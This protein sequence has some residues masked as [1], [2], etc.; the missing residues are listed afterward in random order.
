MTVLSVEA[1]RILWVGF[2][3]LFSAIT[4]LRRLKNSFPS[5]KVILNREM[6]ISSLFYGMLIL[7]GQT[8]HLALSPQKPASNK[9][10]QS[11]GK[12]QET[13]K[14]SHILYW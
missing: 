8:S 7:L 2:I 3:T 11:P 1:D 12:I 4:V 13:E 5:F 6:L 9:R 14:H 10:S